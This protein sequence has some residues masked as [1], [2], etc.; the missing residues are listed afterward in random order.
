MIDVLRS[1]LQ[2]GQT[3][4]SG[5]KQSAVS[6]AHPAD[7]SH[8]Q[9]MLQII[10]RIESRLPG[11][12]R[13]LFVCRKDNAYVLGGTCRTYYSKQIA[14]HTAMAILDYDKLINEIQVRAPK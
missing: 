3:S 10:S 14:Q 9:M 6:S 7:D 13:G 5:S 4:D 8:R 11:R 1:S 12:I 2:A